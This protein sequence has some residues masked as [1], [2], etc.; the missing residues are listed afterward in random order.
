MMIIDALKTRPNVFKSMLKG[1]GQMIGGVTDEQIESYIDMGSAMNRTV[2]KV[3]AY[4]IWYLSLAAKPISEFYKTVDNYTF[5][6]ARYIFLG[7]F[8]FFGYYFCLAGYFILKWIFVRVYAVA[9]LLYG[10]VSGTKAQV[11][12][13]LA[14]KAAQTVANTVEQEFSDV[15]TTTVGKV[16]AAAAGAV[17]AAAVNDAIKN[18]VGA[19]AAS[20][21]KAAAKAEDEFEF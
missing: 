2:L 14:K 5:G 16:A 12:S 17:G 6:S 7:I 3:I 4:A 8:L 9:M 19:A 1:R 10:A 13:E 18:G 11:A 21:P 15:A 20:T